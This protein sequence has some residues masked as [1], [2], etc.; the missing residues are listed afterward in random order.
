MRRR[1]SRVV[2]AAAALTAAAVGTASGG[3][4][5]GP[6][7]ANHVGPTY[8]DDAGEPSLGVSW[9]TG[10]ALL[11]AGLT[12]GKATFG[13]DGSPSWSDAS[14]NSTS[15]ISLDPIA[16]TDPQ[17]GRTWVSQLVLAGSIMEWTD[18]DGATWHTS[19]GSGVPAGADH[20][21]VGG[22][23]YPSEGGY[24]PL[25]SYPHAV[26][27]CSQ[28]VATALCARSDDGGTTFGAGVPAYTLADCNGLHG[29]VKV[30][31]EGAV[32]LP[33]KR[34]G[35]G[36]GVAVSRDAGLTWT[37]AP[38][39][40]VG[41]SNGSDPS[42][43]TA[44]DGTVYVGLVDSKGL[45]R[46]S[47][48]TNHGTSFSTPVPIG[49]DKGIANAAIPAAV[50]G[51]GDRAAVAFLGTTTEGDAQ[52]AKFG[53][54]PDG[55]SYVGAEWHLYVA[56]TYDKGKSWK[57]VDLTP[58]DPVQR[59][60]IC[61][62]GT[63]CSGSDRNLLDFMDAALDRDGR[64]LVGWADGCLDAC[65]TSALVATNT[66]AS[67]GTVSR[68]TKGVLLRKKPGKVVG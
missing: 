28:S 2:L 41:A 1:T 29:H 40:G 36:Q 63:G 46:V 34:C 23:P 42:V 67:Q 25:G 4:T 38:I 8:V 68:Q 6:A 32:Y 30:G 17:T 14:G 26:Y 52:N 11:Q 13:A 45:P 9:K 56:F 37:V 54:S 35:A 55:L 51:D 61:L 39:P 44:D 33:N 48:S 18:D 20:Q 64:V 27:Y 62:G 19:T 53:M 57:T 10:A 43:A 50:A 49:E 58:K 22:G 47:M 12:T 60:R 7:F 59:G 3:T 65:V 15:I 31:P 16:A 66:Y 21:T 24:G 5:T